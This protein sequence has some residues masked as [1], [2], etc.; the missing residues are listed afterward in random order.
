MASQRVKK[1]KI[2]WGSM[3]PDPPRVERALL[4]PRKSFALSQHSPVTLTYS[5]ATVILNENP[6]N[7]LFVT[8]KEHWHGI[9]LSP[10]V[11][12]SPFSPFSP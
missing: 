6:E 5:P 1:S 3:P 2:S 9:P 11:P 4:A 10:L 8:C 7:C 12:V